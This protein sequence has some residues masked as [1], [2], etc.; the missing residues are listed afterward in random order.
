MEPITAAIPA[1]LMLALT[2]VC[3]AAHGTP[4]RLVLFPAALLHA[5]ILS[6]AVEKG[7]IVRKTSEEELS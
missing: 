5:F 7:I 1:H 2:T 4:L 6:N 3:S